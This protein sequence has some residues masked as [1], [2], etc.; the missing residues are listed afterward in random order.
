MFP[1]LGKHFGKRTDYL[2][3]MWLRRAALGFWMIASLQ[4][5]WVCHQPLGAELKS[6]PQGLQAWPAQVRL[7]AR[8]ARG[9]WIQ[10]E[11]SVLEGNLRLV[12]SGYRPL[13]VAA[14][15]GRFQLWADPLSTLA[16]RPAFYIGLILLIWEWAR[17][18]NPRIE[19]NPQEPPARPRVAT[20]QILHSLGQGTQ[21]EVYLAEA[22]SGLKVA[23][24]LI[25]EVDDEFRQR[26]ERE[27]ELCGRMD[28][29]RIVRTL[30]WGSHEGRLWMAQSY[31]PGQSLRSWVNGRGLHAAE[32]RRLLTQICEGLAYAHR[33]GV[34]H[35]DLKP[36]NI[37][38]DSRGQA[39]IGDFGLAR[40]LD[41]QTMTRTDVVLG[42]PAYM[43][44]EQI[45]GEKILRGASDLYALGVIG[46]ELVTGRLPF[47]GDLMQVMM[48]HLRESPQPPSQLR[49][50]LPT[51][52]ESLILKLL[53]KDPAHR[54]GSAEEVMALLREGK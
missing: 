52:L 23:L 41:M 7:Q 34:F 47:Q 9:G 5:A 14:R 30:G 33:L 42:S 19:A 44:P 20:Y 35:R 53:E 54:P 46:Y 27:A 36:D 13:E 39:V 16:E 3:V 15:P 32:V 21:A 40:C 43:S 38:L 1:E 29:P 6:T 11:G 28:H 50:G 22:D 24:K 8:S 4:V 31:L 45:G 17:R 37:L 10:S 49:P 25:K 26:F 2:K 51:G 48:G 18:T 12:A